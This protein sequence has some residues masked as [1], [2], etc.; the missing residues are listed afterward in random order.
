MARVWVHNGYEIDD[1]PRRV[2]LDALWSF[3]GTE[4]YWGRW[5]TRHDVEHELAAA[6]RVVGVYTEAGAMVG[7]ARSVSDGSGFGYLADVYV[8]AEHRGRGL[9]NAL[10]EEM[11]DNGPGAEFRW[12]L[13]TKDAQALY[14]RFGFAEPGPT[15]MERVG[16]RPPPA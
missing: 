8:I 9:G 3:L 11:I 4:A 10:V 5:R 12:L 14:R 7:F 15:V 2:D 13:F 6:W 16:P 1:D